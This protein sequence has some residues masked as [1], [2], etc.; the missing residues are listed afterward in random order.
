MFDLPTPYSL[1]ASPD[2]HDEC[3][4]IY[5]YKEGARNAQGSRLA[6]YDHW[7]EGGEGAAAAG[8]TPSQ[9]T[10][11]IS[12]TTMSTT[13]KTTVTEPASTILTTTPVET[14]T[15]PIGTAPVHT[16]SKSPYQ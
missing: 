2:P 13:T 6:K 15:Q 1:P 3:Y 16:P 12:K 14:T 7:V 11:S 8:P 10:L 5:P 9:L 4:G